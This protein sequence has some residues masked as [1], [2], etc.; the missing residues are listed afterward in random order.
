MMLRSLI[1]SLSI[2]LAAPAVSARPGRARPSPVVKK[3]DARK[4]QVARRARPPI[5]KAPA[6]KRA[7]A[8]AST[9]IQRR[10]LLELSGGGDRGGNLAP[11][12]DTPLE[13]ELQG[14]LDEILGSPW[15]KSAINGVYVIDAV[16]GKELYSY[17]ADRQLN[18]ASNTKLIS[19]ATALELLGGDYT[20]VTR[21]VGPAPGDDGVVAGDV[22]F[23]GSGDPTLRVGHLGDLAESLKSRGVKKI[24]GDLVV[25]SDDRDAVASPWV[26]VTLRGGAAGDLPSVRLTPDSPFFQV[27]NRATTANVKKKRQQRIAVSTQLV[28]TPEGPRV[29][30]IV[31]GKVPPRQELEVTRG[32]PR[33]VLYT[34]HTLRA[35]LLNAGIE[36][37]GDVRQL[38]TRPEP[39][40]GS[41]ELARHDSVPLR[42]LAAMINKPSNNF[43]ADKLIMNVGAEKFGGERTMAKGVKAMNDWLEEIG[44]TGN[45]RL[46]NGSGLSH[47][48]HIS[49]RQIAQV[50]M[51]GAR[52]ERFGREWLD[53]L[54]I[55]GEDGTL[56]GR[57]ADRPSAGFVRGKTGTL[58]GVSTL[59]GFVTLSDDTQVVFAI[60]TAGFR[61]RI[62]QEVRESHAEIADAIY[63]YLRARMGEEAPAAPPPDV[64]L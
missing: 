50:L 5:K 52:D 27:I 37:T 4:R 16:T 1:V 20:Y 24:A 7:H 40:I 19:T 38:E 60:M 59:S 31:S 42:D 2:V 44:V 3:T 11:A 26:R 64:D 58:H 61:N 17:G 54:A 30:V 34:A 63:G 13:R 49:A 14:K 45:Y 43:L 32:V 15:L 8:R 36:V 41:L 57:F 53:S 51:K 56:R 22:L 28:T 33:P 62:K 12:G 35:T 9:L 6:R 21:L 46:E 10:P 47:T 25:G 48:I 55:G 39:P 18:P 23:L 29:K